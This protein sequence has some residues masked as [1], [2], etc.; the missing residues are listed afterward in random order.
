MQVSVRVIANQPL[1]Q[2]FS[3][4]NYNKAFNEAPSGFAYRVPKKSV[5]KNTKPVLSLIPKMELNTANF[6]ERKL[7]EI[8]RDTICRNSRLMNEALGFYW[9][10]HEH[11]PCNAVSGERERFTLPDSEDGKETI[12]RY[13]RF[14]G[15]S[16]HNAGHKPRRHIKFQ[17]TEMKE[18]Y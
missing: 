13:H 17:R 18:I 12:K 1:H 8:R 3:T 4:E 10:D 16:G 7:A 6:V 5:G 14:R 9:N 11:V 15:G 2:F